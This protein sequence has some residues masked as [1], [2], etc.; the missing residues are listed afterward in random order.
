MYGSIHG[1]TENNN[2]KKKKSIKFKRV[3]LFVLLVL[4]SKFFS[5]SLKKHEQKGTFLFYTTTSFKQLHYK[6][7]KNTKNQDKNGRRKK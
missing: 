7:K 2:G 6:L 1:I 4:N 3:N 5:S